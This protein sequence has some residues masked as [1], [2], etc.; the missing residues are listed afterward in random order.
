MKSRSLL[1]WGLPRDAQASTQLTVFIVLT[2]ATILITRGGLA[3]AGYPSIG[4]SRLHIAHVLWGGLLML[5]AMVVQ[6][7]FIG[8]VVKPIAAVFGGIGFGLF[9]DEVGKFVTRDNDYFYRPAVAIIYVTIVAL[10]LAT[11][12][13]HRSR[14][15]QAS[16]RLANAVYQAV[17]GVASGLSAHRLAGAQQHLEAAKSV[18]GSVEVHILLT[19]LPVGEDDYFIRA[20]RTIQAKAE[21]V[22]ESR[23]VMGFTISL[24]VI[25]AVAGVISAAVTLTQI[26]FYPH[27]LATGGDRILVILMSVSA[28]ASTICLLIG[29]AR[30]RNERM[31]AIDWFQR[32]VLIDLLVTQLLDSTISGFRAVFFVFVGLFVL[33]ILA[34]EKTRLVAQTVRRDRTEGTEL[35]R[36]K[37]AE[38]AGGTEGETREIEDAGEELAGTSTKVEHEAVDEIVRDEEQEIE[39]DPDSED[40]L[41]ESDS[42]NEQPQQAVTPESG[43][44]VWP[45]GKRK[46]VPVP[47]SEPEISAGSHVIEGSKRYFRP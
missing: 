34:A 20:T 5:L 47:Q 37:S 3:A 16:E 38:I 41:E 25:Q 15:L 27:L 42:E 26:V 24:I 28:A 39:V 11:H 40:D 44:S 23:T 46:D 35:T 13:M 9:I 32:A 14:P 4:G 30:F 19:E 7:S 21:R 45:P 10:I 18:P 12:F 22:F 8:P 2:V 6:L 33:A 36:D 43:E 1:R 31:V 29:L 17:T